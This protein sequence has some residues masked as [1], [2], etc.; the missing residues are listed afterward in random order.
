MRNPINTLWDE[1]KMVEQQIE[2]LYEE[3]E[4]ISVADAGCTRIRKIPGIG[5]YILR[6]TVQLPVC[7][8]STLQTLDENA[9]L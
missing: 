4:G 1:W 6:S 2:E 5:P 8:Q 9:L 7:R 3:L